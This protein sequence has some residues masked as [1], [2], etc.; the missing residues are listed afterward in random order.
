MDKKSHSLRNSLPDRCPR[1]AKTASVHQKNYLC[2][3]ERPAIISIFC[4]FTFPKYFSRHVSK[5]QT[6]QWF[7]FWW[8]L[9]VASDTIWVFFCCISYRITLWNHDSIF[10][11]YCIFLWSTKINAE[12]PKVETLVD[13][14]STNMS[15]TILKTDH[16]HF[17]MASYVSMPDSN[18][19]TLV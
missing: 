13:R 15:S 18:F 8:F 12:Q 7:K 1:P 2:W 14:M 6:F 19:K 4:T 16:I 3:S 9:S 11:C 5:F 17:F 10:F